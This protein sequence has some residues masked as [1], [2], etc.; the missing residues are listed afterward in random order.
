MSK[1]TVYA[2]AG[3]G[4]VLAIGLAW[5]VQQDRPSSAA[6]PAAGA[7]AGA[8][9]SRGMPAVEVATVVTSRLVD[10]AQAVGTLKSRQSV[11]LRPEV[12]G[13]IV[14][15]GFEEGRPVRQGQLLV[16]LDDSLPRAELS[17]AQAQLSIAQANLQRNRELVSQNFVSRRVLDES[18]ATLQVAQAQVQL[19]QARLARTQVVAPFAGVAGIRQV[20][21]GDFVR[22]GTDLVNLE[23]LSLLMVDFRLPERYQAQ[24]QLGQIVDVALDALPGQTL[25]ATV[26][27]IDPLIDVN[28]RS[29]LVRAA[30]E[31]LQT[32]GLRPG[33]FARVN[34]VLSVDE[35]A[36]TI[37][38][39]AVVP[40][41]GRQTV[42]VLRPPPEGESTPPTAHRVE[43]QLGVRRGATVQV[44]SGLEPGQTVVV[45]GQQRLQRDGTP[46][47][48][49][50]LN[51]P[52][53]GQPGGQ[54]LAPA[55]NQ[56]RS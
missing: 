11:V 28:G 25:T 29:L 36:I 31:G 35:Q 8:G 46:V 39:E 14:R 7:P 10:D 44:L 51:A 41:G 17:Q 47:R 53:D 32:Q 27:A 40:L 18:Q 55:S 37:P 20:N 3:A 16:Q 13:R 4:L 48:V 30:I 38:E 15:F 23:D 42:I 54:S 2:L 43:V 49:V 19:A 22:E 24:I 21:L 45:A 52:R 1:K 5:W 34:V 33:L 50:D 6:S 56:P 12:G 26:Q 9:G